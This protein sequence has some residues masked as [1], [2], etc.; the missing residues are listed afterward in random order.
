MR[1]GRREEMV[2]TVREITTGRLRRARV[3]STGR[4]GGAEAQA[5]GDFVVRVDVDVCTLWQRA[6][7][8]F[9]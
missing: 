3:V 9:R 2:G 1:I 5:R 8:V 6:I 7:A 4:H